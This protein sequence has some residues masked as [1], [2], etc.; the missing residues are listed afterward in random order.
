MRMISVVA[1]LF[2]LTGCAT[3]ARS[4]DPLNGRDVITTS[5]G[6]FVKDW[7]SCLQVANRACNGIYDIKDRQEF[8]TIQAHGSQVRYYLFLTAEC[9]SRASRAP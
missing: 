4:V 8:S 5:C 2:T 6:G 3:S 7:S 1:V 9:E